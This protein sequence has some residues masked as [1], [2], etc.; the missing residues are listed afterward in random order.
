MRAP[1]RRYQRLISTLI[2]NR[3]DSDY[4]NPAALDRALELAETAVRLD[5]RL[6]QARAQLG[7]VL[8]LKRQHDA[9]VAEFERAF[10]LNANFIDHRYAFV[11]TGVGEPASAIE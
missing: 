6:P 9:A 11:L 7:F 5:P 2:T 8:L 4:A 3:S 10:A 1:R